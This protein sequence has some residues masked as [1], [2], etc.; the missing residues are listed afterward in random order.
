MSAIFV[1]LVL[2]LLSA[3]PIPASLVEDN[4]ETE[5][6]TKAS[7]VAS[8]RNMRRHDP[9]RHVVVTSEDQITSDA[10]VRPP[11]SAPAPFAGTRT[12]CLRC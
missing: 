4:D 3:T 11:I 1:A 10:A 2:A 7:V 5:L 6:V 12:S 8:V 9:A